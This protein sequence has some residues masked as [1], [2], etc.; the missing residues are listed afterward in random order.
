MAD[1]CSILDR[2]D[3]LALDQ[4]A[5]DDGLRQAFRLITDALIR[6]Q[7]VMDDIHAAATKEPPRSDIPALLAEIK[8]ILEQQPEQIASAIEVALNKKGT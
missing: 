6:M 8:R 2:L 1:L 3:Q 7:A 4:K 5:R